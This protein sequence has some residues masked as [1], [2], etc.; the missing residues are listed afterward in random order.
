[1]IIFLCRDDDF[2]KFNDRGEQ[3]ALM[4]NQYQQMKMQLESFE[5]T[6][7]EMDDSARWVL[8]SWQY[9]ISVLMIPDTR[10]YRRRI[11]AL[12]AQL[13]QAQSSRHN[14]QLKHQASIEI[15]TFAS[16]KLALQTANTRLRNENIE[17]K[18]EVEEMR[19]MLE[20]LKAQH[21]GKRGLVSEPRASPVQFI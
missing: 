6:Q 3:I 7:A 13:S 11:Q 14:N 18:D 15:A 19:A 21:S 1:M 9:L 2:A 4:R 20:V 17:L 8:L 10:V 5:K 16:E 12:E